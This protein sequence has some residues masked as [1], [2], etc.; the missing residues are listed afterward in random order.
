MEKDLIQKAQKR[1]KNSLERLYRHF[2]GYAMSIALRYSG[3]REEACEI[4]NDSFMKAFDKLEQFSLE[5]S[6]KGWFRRIIINT[7]VDY[8]RKNLKHYSA[9]DIDKAGA[10][11]CDPGVIDELSREDILRSLGELPETLRLVFNMYEIEGYKHHEIGEK[12]GI[13]ASTCRT[14]LARAKEK[15]REK[16]ITINQIRNEGAVR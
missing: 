6:F 5:N 7:S 12:L 10:E 1:D 13:P 3:S 14:Y 16:I 11:T 2:Y 15:L 9:M 8:Y 4:V